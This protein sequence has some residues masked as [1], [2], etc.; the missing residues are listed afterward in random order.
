ME[1]AG[2]YAALLVQGLL[3]WKTVSSIDTIENAKSCFTSFQ[4]YSLMCDTFKLVHRLGCW[5]C[6]P[7]DC[8]CRSRGALAYDL[9]H[10]GQAGGSETMIVRDEGV[11]AKTVASFDDRDRLRTSKSLV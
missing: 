2:G 11:A 3:L 10:G 5:R 1:Q 8:W 4:R 7:R 9:Q 6:L